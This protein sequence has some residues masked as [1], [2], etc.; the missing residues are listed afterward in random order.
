M[1]ENAVILSCMVETVCGFYRGGPKLQEYRTLRGK[2]IDF[3]CGI[4]TV[5]SGIVWKNNYT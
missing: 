2:D 3:E 5:R 4:P 1:V